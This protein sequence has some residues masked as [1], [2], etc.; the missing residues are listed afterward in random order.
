MPEYLAPGVYVEEIDTG[1]KPIEGVS[2]STAGVVGVTERGPVGVPILITSYGEFERVFGGTLSKVD[3]P[4]HCYLPYAVDGFFTNGG[5]RVWITRA[6]NLLAV[7]SERILLDRGSTND[8]TTF[9][10]DRV[11]TGASQVLV[12][13]PV[14]GAFQAGQLLRVGDGSG[15]EHLTVQAAPTSVAQTVGRAVLTAPTYA[16]Y[17]QTAKV[18][19]LVLSPEGTATNLTTGVSAGSNLLTVASIAD[20]SPG[21]VIRIDSG[22]NR[23]FLTVTR[24]GQNPGE[25]W[26]SAPLQKGHPAQSTTVA[27][28]VLPQSPAQSATLRFRIPVGTGFLV[29][30]GTTAPNFAASSLIRIQFG[31][32][33]FY[34]G[35]TAAPQAV[36]LQGLTFNP[37]PQ[38]HDAGGLVTQR[39]QLL[40]VRAL[41]V[42]AWGDRVRVFLRSPQRPL[43]TTRVSEKLDDSHIRLQ[44]TAN[45]E[46]GTVLVITDSAGAENIVRVNAINRGQRNLI[47]LNPPFVSLR[48]GDAVRSEE[49][50]IGVELLRPNDPA[51]PS[52]NN[53]AIVV[54]NFPYL[55]LDPEHSRYIQKVIGTTWTDGNPEDDSGLPLR[56][57][58][59]RSEGESELIRVKDLNPPVQ[60]Q[61]APPRPGPDL[62]VDIDPVTGLPRPARLALSGGRDGTA[63]PDD[64]IGQNAVEPEDRTG[65]HSLK[66]ID[67]ISIVAAPG[68]VDPTVQQALI[69]HC[70]LL[71]Y[72]FAVLDGPPPP[73]DTLQGVRDLRQQYDSKYAAVYHPWIQIPDRYSTLPG[74][75]PPLPI[76][77]SGH[78]LGV[79]ARTD[80]ERGVH[81]APANEVLRGAIGLQ[82]ILNKEQHDILNPF[83]VNINVIR[84]FRPD[85]RGIRVYG[86]RVITSDPDFKYVNVRRLLIFIEA[87]LDRGLQWVVFE[88]N[89]EPLWAR[90]RRAITNFLNVVWR[91]G[92]L[93]GV[94]PEEGFFVKCDRTTMT[95]T[96]IDN[97]RLICVIGV[98]PVKPAE[99][100]IIRIGLWTAQAD[101]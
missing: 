98:A 2:T 3:F 9:L 53:T 77:P 74:L 17:P 8:P 93:E 75:Q 54:E 16:D 95:Q 68:N 52:R 45:V 65:I 26:L 7:R 72:R 29:F 21:D 25:V 79:Y 46:V 63:Q 57:S 71:R 39:G 15:V 80:I 69:N 20:L 34:H 56:R 70:E 58:D 12:V 78:V 19:G 36:P 87:S 85:N 13:P 59:R 82:R 41:D 96:D 14:A 37:A 33:T 51:V 10:A 90:V 100:V 35:L 64:F 11:Q 89:A 44:A 101:N 18:D 4:A 6:G 5:K 83:P 62:L 38:A 42:G 48:V 55:T 43:L 81:K 50:D 73:G 24:F 60:P 40:Q 91:N 97:G 61:L 27:R 22:A 94:S 28:Q 67:S 30:E 49:F 66:N 88:P 84:D 92:A 76:P 47:T 23:E 86:G 31:A 32:S 99:F 1:T